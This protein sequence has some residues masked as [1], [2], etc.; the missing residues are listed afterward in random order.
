M[1]PTYIRDEPGKSPMGMDLIPVYEDEA[2]GGSMITIDPVDQQNMGVRT[3]TVERRTLIGQSALLVW[4][5]TTSRSH[6]WLTPKLTAGS[7]ISMST[8]PGRR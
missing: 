4:S 6:I 8:K 1:D 2:T 3:A 7:N 5:A